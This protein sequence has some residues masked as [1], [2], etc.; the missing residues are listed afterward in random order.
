MNED[1]A[2]SPAS[3][4]APAVANLQSTSEKEVSGVL[5]KLLRS[6]AQ[7]LEETVRFLGQQNARLHDQVSGLTQLS[8]PRNAAALIPTS[9]EVFNQAEDARKLMRINAQMFE[10]T[11]RALG[12]QNTNLLDQV[13]AL[14]AEL[15]VF[16]QPAI[17]LDACSNQDE[18]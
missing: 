10:G 4:D 15:L 18:S 11:I 9:A 13:S 8:L 2:S 3:A 12:A 7:I 17:V 16:L 6:N 5:R 14:T 1:A